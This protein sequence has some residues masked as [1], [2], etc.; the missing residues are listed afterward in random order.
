MKERGYTGD[1]A[2][3]AIAAAAAA[4]AGGESDGEDSPV[5]A[6][7][8]KNGHTHTR[9]PRADDSD[10]TLAELVD[11]AKKGAKEFVPPADRARGEPPH[12]STNLKDLTIFYY[13]NKEGWLRGTVKAPSTAKEAQD[14]YNWSV[15]F[16][17][18]YD[19]STLTL[20]DR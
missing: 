18:Y 9:A 2:A 10:A 19:V 6:L 5:T 7:G 11:K 13:F 20:K 3:A 8:A 1:E 4:V 15:K 16:I 14:G 12:T 17:G